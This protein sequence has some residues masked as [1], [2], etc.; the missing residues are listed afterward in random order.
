M[1]VQP[2][3]SKVPTLHT[4]NGSLLADHETMSDFSFIAILLPQITSWA[5][6][7]IC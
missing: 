4:G 5:N 3:W 6:M 2:T 7:I 1:S